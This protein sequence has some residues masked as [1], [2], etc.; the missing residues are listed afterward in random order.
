MQQAHTMNFQVIGLEDVR[1]KLKAREHALLN[2]PEWLSMEEICRTYSTSRSTVYRRIREG[3]FPQ[4]SKHLGA[5]S[6]R[7]N[8]VE[9]DNMMMANRRAE[10]DRKSKGPEC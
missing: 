2:P 4:P 5:A 1:R 10:H 7:W 9:I 6:P 8:R 3:K